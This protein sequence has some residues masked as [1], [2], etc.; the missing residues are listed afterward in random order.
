VV[1]RA[2]SGSSLSAPLEFLFATSLLWG[3]LL[4]V[5]WQILRAG[6]NRHR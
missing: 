5:L 1:L 3:V 4:C 6:L 2:Q